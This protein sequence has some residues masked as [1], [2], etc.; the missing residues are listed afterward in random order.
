VQRQLP[1]FD[2]PEYVITGV[3]SIDLPKAEKISFEDVEDVMYTERKSFGNRQRERET[4]EL[5][6]KRFDASQAELKHIF[7]YGASGNRFV[8]H[9]SS[10]VFGSVSRCRIISILL[11]VLIISPMDLRNTL[12][13]RME[14]LQQQVEHILHQTYR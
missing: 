4:I 13:N 10:G 1:K 11:A 5:E 2:L 9:T 3:A 7:R 12:I 14:V 8:L 6:V